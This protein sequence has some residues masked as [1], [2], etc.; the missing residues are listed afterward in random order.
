MK[1]GKNVIKEFAQLLLQS[2]QE[3]D[4]ESDNDQILEINVKLNTKKSVQKLT[5]EGRLFS[6]ICF[7]TLALLGGLYTTLA[8]IMGKI[9]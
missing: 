9:E 4:K 1:N 3:E 7:D 6:S 5:Q 2:K 8:S